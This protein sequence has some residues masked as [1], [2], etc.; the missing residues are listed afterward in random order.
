MQANKQL[1]LFIKRS[2]SFTSD[3]TGGSRLFLSA[4]CKDNSADRHVFVTF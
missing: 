4:A 1:E 3:V 2:N